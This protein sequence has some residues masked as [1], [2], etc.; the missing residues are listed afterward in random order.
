MKSLPYDNIASTL[1]GWLPRWDRST[2]YKLYLTTVSLLGF[3]LIL[4]GVV[5]FLSYENKLNFALLFLLAA[6]TAIATTSVPVSDEA[7][8][9]YHVGEAISIAAV[10]AFGVGAAAIIITTF[11]IGMWLIKPVD[12]RTWKKSWQQLTFNVGMHCVAIACAGYAL[13]F[14]RG[15]L[16]PTTVWGP[17]HSLATSGIC[18]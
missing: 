18:L 9:T 3:F 14:I 10:P 1:A 6:V 15:W 7:G 2:L 12:G 8:I 16:D 13:L 4:F 17:D 5:G 11:N